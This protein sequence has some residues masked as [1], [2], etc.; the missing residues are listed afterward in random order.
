[1]GAFVG[2]VFFLGVGGGDA[3]LAFVASCEEFAL[4]FC[5]L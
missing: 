5:C 4:L 1:M 2:F 3:V